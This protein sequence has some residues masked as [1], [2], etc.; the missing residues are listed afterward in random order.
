MA[1]TLRIFCTTSATST[2]YMS[3]YAQASQESQFI[4][5]YC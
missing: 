1:S 3:L 2:L 4:Q 5:I